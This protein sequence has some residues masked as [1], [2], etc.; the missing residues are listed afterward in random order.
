MKITRII[1]H[2]IIS[3]L[4]SINNIVAAESPTDL[5]IMGKI[6]GSDG[7]NFAQNITADELNFRSNKFD[8]KA[9]I[10]LKTIDKKI[11]TEE[12]IFDLSNVDNNL[13]HQSNGQITLLP[14]LNENVINDPNYSNYDYLLLE[15]S[16]LVNPHDLALKIKLN[17]L[18][19]NISFKKTR[20]NYSFDLENKVIERIQAQSFLPKDNLYLFNRILGL[21]KKDK[22]WRYHSDKASHIKSEETENRHILQRKFDRK[23]ITNNAIDLTLE[24]DYSIDR[25]NLRISGNNLSTTVVLWEDI[26]K[27]INRSKDGLLN[28]R[29]LVFQLLDEKFK[30]QDELFLEEIIVYI[31]KKNNTINSLSPLR[32]LAFL[33]VADPGKFMNNNTEFIL[34]VTDHKDLKISQ[35]SVN[36]IKFSLDQLPNNRTIKSLTISD[37]SNNII[38]Q[39][40][41]SGG[42][43]FSQA[44]LVKTAIFDVPILFGYGENLLN[45]WLSESQFNFI[46]TSLI[47]SPK[48]HYYRP[49]ASININKYNNS[50]ENI[51]I[52]LDDEISSDSFLYL[53]KIK[54][55]K[56][57]RGV[58]ISFF[59]SDQHLKDFYVHPNNDIVSLNEAYFKT[60]MPDC[61]ICKKPFNK[62]TIKYL[63]SPPDSNTFSDAIEVNTKKLVDNS[64]IFKP[65]YV[66][67]IA[68]FEIQHYS[69]EDLMNSEAFFIFNRK[70]IIDKMDI[71][72]INNQKLFNLFNVDSTLDSTLDLVNQNMK[73]NYE[74]PDNFIFKKNCWLKLKFIGQDFFEDRLVCLPNLKGTVNIDIPSRADQILFDTN[75]ISESID[76]QGLNNDLISFSGE[77]N[78]K[79]RTNVLK[80]YFLSNILNFNGK[81]YLPTSVESNYPASSIN[82]RYKINSNSLQNVNLSKFKFTN[83]DDA[84]SSVGDLIIYPETDFDSSDVLNNLFYYDTGVLIKNPLIS[85]LF[86]YGIILCL[87]VLVILS[88]AFSV[89]YKTVSLTFFNSVI[90]PYK[91]FVSRSPLKGFSNNLNISLKVKFI[92]LLLLSISLAAVS[93]L[94]YWSQSFQILLFITMVVLFFTYSSFCILIKPIIEKN[95]SKSIALIYR[96]PSGIYFTGFIVSICVATLLTLLLKFQAADLI[97]V[98][99][100][101]MLIIG[102]VLEVKIT[103]KNNG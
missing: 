57:L 88:R 60:F 29:L 82:L 43:K 34:S 73:L 14:N 59:N 89:V 50:S 74:A 84:Y 36:I 90:I 98:V 17:P 45:K 31:P 20:I 55:L 3:L 99:A 92:V 37:Q 68:L 2:I 85:N 19:E 72:V 101:Y 10:N 78:T 25:V 16:G 7:V 95:F 75:D 91:A 38:N 61:I 8:L 35:H 71:P 86:L 44:K 100:Y 42:I 21:D 81:D 66:G 30:S 51:N 47:K 18:D 64:E 83:A 1:L 28:V 6:E 65:L 62:I 80:E 15:Y 39:N 23:S 94:K 54:N 22:V 56:N 5:F 87:I 96:R 79:Y 11:V 97:T 32:S 93:M 4:V 49:E 33:P 58:K 76:W 40:L 48:L 69:R 9:N 67:E 41:E 63:L 46:E 13:V 24:K 26:P 53:E 12:L 102:L 52:L 77:V 70:I 103:S 27:K